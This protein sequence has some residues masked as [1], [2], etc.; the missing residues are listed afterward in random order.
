M[1]SK[2]KTAKGFSVTAYQ[3]DAKTLLAFNLPNRKS[4]ANLAGFTI[5][6]QPDGQDPYFLFNFLRFKE[7]G[8]HTQVATEPA[9]SSVNAPFHKFRW[10]HVPG[11]VHQGTKPF[12]GPYTYTVTPRFFNDEQ[13]LL[14]IDPERGVAVTI[15]VQPFRKKGLELGFTRGFMQSQAFVHHFGLKALVRPKNKELLF[16]TSQQSGINSA[17]EPYTFRDEYDWMGYTAREKIFALLQEVVDDKELHVDVFALRPQRTRPV[18]GAAQA[19]GPGPHPHH[20]RQRGAAPQHNQAGARGRVR[21]GLR[22]R[23][24]RPGRDETRQVRPLRP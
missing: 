2:S 23:R 9:V 18:P 6:C 17:G 16:D 4:A 11:S 1:A 8:R 24:A 22:R 12:M 3:G 5:Q 10:L 15:D 20:P 19:R 13:S 14:P 7:P 21:E